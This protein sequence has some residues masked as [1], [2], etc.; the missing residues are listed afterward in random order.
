MEATKGACGVQGKVT[1]LA[2]GTQRISWEV[3]SPPDAGKD[4]WTIQGSVYCQGTLVG[5]GN[6]L[7]IVDGIF[8]TDGEGSANLGTFIGA[9][10]DS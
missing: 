7:Q 5:S 10:E 2:D 4:V 9:K 1:H 3:Y 6:E 8:G